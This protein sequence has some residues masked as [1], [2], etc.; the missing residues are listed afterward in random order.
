MWGCSSGLSASG[1]GSDIDQLRFGGLGMCAVRSRPPPNPLQWYPPKYT[2]GGPPTTG[3]PH[4][5][6]YPAWPAHQRMERRLSRRARTE[7]ECHTYTD[8]WCVC[9]CLS[10]CLSLSVSVC[11]CLSLSVCLSVSVCL[12]LS[13]CLSVCLCLSVCSN[14]LKC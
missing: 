3:V 9:V 11:L 10:V 5:V 7:R 1:L 8:T 12:C 14:A 4:P 13:V 2:T 6:S